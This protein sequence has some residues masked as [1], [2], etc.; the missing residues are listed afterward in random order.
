MVRIDFALETCHDGV[1]RGVAPRQSS[2]RLESPLGGRILDQLLAS[3]AMQAGGLHDRAT[4]GDP[5]GG[6]WLETHHLAR[7][8][9]PQ[10]CP[11]ST[12]FDAGRW[13]AVR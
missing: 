2:V 7:Q 13:V 9:E 3:Y 10:L 8:V 12:M 5:F 4:T 11:C 1:R 6:A